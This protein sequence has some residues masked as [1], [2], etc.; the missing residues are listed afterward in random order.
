MCTGGRRW[1]ISTE[2]QEVCDKEIEIASFVVKET[3]SDRF[4]RSAGVNKIV[5]SQVKVLSALFILSRK[6]SL[7][8][9][10]GN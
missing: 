8:V 6:P 10:T 3:E 1:N 9:L 4:S 7:K 5:G 2:E